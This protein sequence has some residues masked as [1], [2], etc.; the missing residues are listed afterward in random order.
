MQSKE[1]IGNLSIHNHKNHVLKLSNSTN[2][3]IISCYKYQL[4][5]VDIKDR[6]NP[7]LLYSY[8]PGIG[9]VLDF[10]FSQNDEYILMGGNQLYDII[11]YDL[12]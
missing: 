7:T 1:E 5:F 2:M 9:L 10:S 6:S 8:N 4:Y 12:N 11:L 3:A